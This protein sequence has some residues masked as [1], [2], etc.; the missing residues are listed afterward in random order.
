MTEGTDWQASL[1]SLLVLLC[2]NP[3]ICFSFSPIFPERG[4]RGN[5]I[6]NFTASTFAQIHLKVLLTWHTRF[7]LRSLFHIV[8]LNVRSSPSSFWWQMV[9]ITKGYNLHR[10]CCTDRPSR[11]MW[12]V[13]QCGL[14]GKPFYWHIDFFYVPLK[15]NRCFHWHFLFFWCKATQLAVNSNLTGGSQMVILSVSQGLAAL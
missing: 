4:F 11:Q 5:I 12:L 3:V 10:L 1:P 14:Q 2:I 7:H 13:M 8:F 6:K 9:N 15:L